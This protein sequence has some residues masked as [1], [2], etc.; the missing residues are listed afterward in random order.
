MKPTLENKLREILIE[1]GYCAQ[2]INNRDFMVKGVNK[3]MKMGV[4][5]SIARK[6]CVYASKSGKKHNI[7]VTFPGIQFSKIGNCV[8]AADLMVEAIFRL[9]GALY[10]DN[11]VRDCIRKR[12]TLTAP[13]T[14]CQSVGDVNK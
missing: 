6:G 14:K 2:E 4:V 8:A 5:I 3:A 13:C 10:S 1:A 12:L 7:R 11:R 9:I